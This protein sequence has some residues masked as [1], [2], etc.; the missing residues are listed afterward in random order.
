MDH[1]W[2]PRAERG[3]P[4]MSWL[5][6]HF[7]D[8]LAVHAIFSF[9]ARRGGT[10]LALA[11]GYVVEDGAVR[12][13]KSGSG[14]TT[15]GPERYAERVDLQLVDSS[16]RRWELSGRG[17]TSSVESQFISATAR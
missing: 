5:H 12:G 3:A 16:D 13:L 11:H 10:D 6:A 17:L 4:N 2:G 15:R 9:D 14:V 7:D 1:S 8:D